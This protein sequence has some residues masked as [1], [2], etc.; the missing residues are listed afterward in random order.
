LISLL[1]N[2]VFSFDWDRVNMYRKY[3]EEYCEYRIIR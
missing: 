2:N 1:K 3:L